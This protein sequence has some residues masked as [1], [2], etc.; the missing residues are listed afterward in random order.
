MRPQPG[1]RKARGGGWRLVTGFLATGFVLAGVCR[2]QEEAIEDRLVEVTV[3]YQEP[4][5]FQPWQNL[6]PKQRRGYAIRLGEAQYL[7]T[8]NLVR[9][10]KLVQLRKARTGEKLEARVVAADVRIDLALLTT[11]GLAAR[12]PA[13]TVVE[14]LKRQDTVS[15]LQFDQTDALQR[16]DG[17]VLQISIEELPRAPYATLTFSLL[18]DLNVNGEGAPVVKDG[19]LAGLITSYSNS[20]RTGRMIPYPI[21][22]RFL[23]DA[24]R[25]PYVGSAVAGF[26]WKVLVDLVKRNYLGLAGRTGGI[27]VTSCRVGSGAQA[28]LQPND[29]LLEWDGHELDNLGFYE[30]PDFGRLQFAYLI[31]GRRSVGE[32]IPVRLLREGREQA[33]KLTLSKLEDAAALIPE[34]VERARPAYLVEGG[35]VLRELDGHFLRSFGGDWQRNVDPRLVH[36]YVT[37]RQ[38]PGTPG[39]RVVVLGG[40]LP[41]AVNVGYEQFR[42]HIVERVNGEP[43]GN[44]ADVFRLVDRDQHLLSL[45]LRS[46]G[47]DIV[48]DPSRLDEANR[49]LSE[50]Y[51]IPRR[52]HR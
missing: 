23:R 4:N 33:V 44:M 24:A 47:I 20:S 9:N 29:V 31:H 46:V 35:F 40:I 52:R 21:V 45:G 25:P 38:D 14:K 48:L 27:L 10:H 2:G 42:N 39:E 51:R 8:E 34:N 19:R 11:D 3:A 6:Q 41:D 50:T 5:P 16:G 49:R 32:T 26:S 36:L 28:V 22:N 18:T 43:V 30:D 13:I 12:F 1:I 15:I 7:T 17:E 37:R